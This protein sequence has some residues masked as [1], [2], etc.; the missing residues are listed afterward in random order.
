MVK[1]GD[2]Y[3]FLTV[4]SVIPF[5]DGRYTARCR[6]VCG[7]IISL[8]TSYLERGSFRSCG[9]QR[10]ILDTE[11]CKEHDCMQCT[12]KDD[13]PKFYCKYEGDFV[14]ESKGKN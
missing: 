6:C 3:K 13:C 8:P 2:E 1:K 9:C 5:A 7:K 10:G 4:L 12:D 11:F 14:D